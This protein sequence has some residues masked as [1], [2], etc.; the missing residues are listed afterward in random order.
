MSDHDPVEK[1]ARDLEQSIRQELDAMAAA[2]RELAA[3]ARRLG[4]NART[5]NGIKKATEVWSR[6][7]ED[8]AQKVEDEGPEVTKSLLG[9][10]PVPMTESVNQ[11]LADAVAGDPTRKKA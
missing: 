10:E 8:V 2:T 6:A 3:R 4:A 5:V 11:A 1:A 9:K 7:Y